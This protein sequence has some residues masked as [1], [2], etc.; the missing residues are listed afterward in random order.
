MW[1]SVTRTCASHPTYALFV[2]DGHAPSWGPV[3]EFT[4][5]GS[6]WGGQPAAAEVIT[7]NSVLEIITQGLKSS[8]Q[9]ISLQSTNRYWFPTWG[10]T[11]GA[12]Q[13]HQMDRTRKDLTETWARKSSRGKFNPVAWPWMAPSWGFGGWLVRIRLSIA[14]PCAYITLM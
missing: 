9:I 13:G 6:S 11:G 8:G 2:Q 4:P 12:C 1:M 10:V 3:T 14:P 5:E 7:S